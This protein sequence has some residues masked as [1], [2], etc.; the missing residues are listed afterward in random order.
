MDESAS[1]T[2]IDLN[3]GPWTG[4]AHCCPESSESR[5]MMISSAARVM[6]SVVVSPAAIRPAFIL[7]P[8][9]SPLTSGT[10]RLRHGRAAAVS[11][12]ASASRYA[13]AD[14][15][16]AMPTPPKLASEEKST[17]YSMSSLAVT[18]CAFHA[19]TAFALRT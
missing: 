6:A 16:I 18:A 14:E 1:S 3:R 11:A 2:L 7:A 5:A 10:T 12:M 8:A 17:Q 9:P 13:L 4:A 15:C 19:P